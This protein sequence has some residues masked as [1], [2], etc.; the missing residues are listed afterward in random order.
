MHM[1]KCHRFF[2]RRFTLA[3]ALMPLI[4]LGSYAPATAQDNDLTFQSG[5]R[6][7]NAKD[8]KGAINYFLAAEKESAYDFRPVY[9]QALCRHRMG[10]VGAARQLYGTLIHR[11]PDS[12]GAE[13][14]RKALSINTGSP[15]PTFA[16]GSGLQNMQ[17]SQDVLPKSTVAKGEEIDGKPAVIVKVGGSDIKMI[18]DTER[19]ESLLGSNVAVKGRL[20]VIALEGRPGKSAEDGV[21]SCF[22][23]TVGGI[24]RPQ[25]PLYFSNKDKDAAVLGADFLNGYKV[26]FNKEKGEVTFERIAG[27]GDPFGA[28]MALYK[29][30][31]FREALPLLRSAV[32]NKP[33]DPRA[34]Y[35]LANCLQKAGYIEEAKSTYRKVFKRFSNSEAGFLSRVALEQ[36]DPSFKQEMR[37][38]ETAQRSNSGLNKMKKE[39]WTE[40]PYVIENSRY[41]VKVYFDNQPMEAYF[42][43]QDSA[44]RFSAD[45]IRQVDPAYLN[46]SGNVRTESSEGPESNQAIITT[47]WNIKL[48]SVRMGK[49]EA[50]DVPGQVIETRGV[51]GWAP[52]Y[53]LLPRPTVCGYVLKG[54]RFDV[55]T[56]RKVIKIWRPQ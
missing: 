37:A 32:A 12:E 17:V 11:F 3:L 56:T 10:Q 45:M 54:Y 16:K 34:L 22:D 39:E 41:R 33:Q 21:Y 5:V 47:S 52:D 7:F 28:G 27:A 38:L 24:K 26:A 30:N 18:V 2:R 36:M 49:I 1:K 46:D 20:N 42:E 48:K 19:Q 23:V 15:N 31:K 9:Y 43:F 35:C 13:L 51:R 29:K 4:L 6:C 44:C 14:A 55:D 25:L 50:R 40:V 8:Y 53:G